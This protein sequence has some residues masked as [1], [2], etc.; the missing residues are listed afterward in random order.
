MKLDYEKFIEDLRDEQVIYLAAS[1]NDK[2]IVRTVSPLIYENKLYFYTGANTQKYEYMSENNNIAFAFDYYQ[3]EGK[4]EFL[5]NP[6]E[7][8]NIDLK[9]AYIK[10]YNNAFKEPKEEIDKMI[11]C[12][13]NF[14]NIKKWVFDS[15]NKELPIGIA[16]KVFM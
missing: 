3:V 16:E 8:Q 11:F 9:N 10:K 13:I 14:K 6:M 5:G 15:E 1:N 2:V 12:K 7:N 4:V